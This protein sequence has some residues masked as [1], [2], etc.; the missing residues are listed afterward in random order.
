MVILL[1]RPSLRV[2][3]LSL[4]AILGL[5]VWLVSCVCIYGGGDLL[6]LVSTAIL[7]HRMEPVLSL[8]ALLTCRGA[9][10]HLFASQPPRLAPVSYPLVRSLCLAL[11]S[12]LRTQLISHKAFCDDPSPCP[13]GSV[14][15]A[16]T[17]TKTG[18]MDQLS[19]PCPLQLATSGPFSF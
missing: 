15:Q 7:P 10:N 19:Q 3:E 1:S 13:L 2:H 4:K 17:A 14:C 5:I 8:F 12:L 16:E 11:S 6:A 9:W 18:D